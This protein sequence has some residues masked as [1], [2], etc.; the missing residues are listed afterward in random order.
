MT[1]SR[2][3]QAYLVA[4][5][6]INASA[7]P[8]G[9]EQVSFISKELR[10]AE[11]VLR[12]VQYQPTSDTKAHVVLVHGSGGWSDVR[13]GHYARA[14][15]SAGYAVLAIDTFG[16]RGISNTAE[17]QAKLTMTQNT[18]DALAARRFLIAQGANPDRMALMGFSR[19]GIVALYNADRT[20]VPSEADRFPVAIPFYPGCSNRPREPKPASIVFMVLGEKDDWTG[21][22]P[23]QDLA[24]DYA[25]AGGNIKIKIYPGSS[26]GFDGDPKH[27]AMFRLPTVDNYM[28]CVVYVEPDGTQS[29]EGRTFPAADPAIYAELRKSCV[30]KGATIWTN[31]AQKAT[32]TKDVI[33]FLDTIFAK[34]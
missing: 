13:E 34:R 3:T 5:A 21:V 31:P 26:H 29:F 18:L 25:K 12:A 28:N 4:F 30:R 6:S 20:M 8:A 27:T 32:A 22:K 10:G 23:C 1:L 24:A 9:G 11:I 7:Q 33:E 16:Q 17:D 14:L 2:L 15:S 19:G